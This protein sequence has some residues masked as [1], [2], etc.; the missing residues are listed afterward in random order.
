MQAFARESLRHALAQPWAIERALG[1]WLTEPK[2]HVWF[3]PPRDAST[4]AGRGLRL[5]RRTRM[6]HDARCIYVNGESYSV[7]G[8]D[9]VLL[10][11]L[12][13]ARFLASRDAA[14]LSAQARCGVDEW[15]AAGWLHSEGDDDGS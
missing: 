7:R 2:P 14:R 6:G 3:E 15:L 4:I 10:H 9:A 12:A 8:R 13:D 11:R 1:E 5:D